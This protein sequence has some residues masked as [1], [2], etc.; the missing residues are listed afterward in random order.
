MDKPKLF[1]A[2]RYV[3]VVRLLDT[4]QTVGATLAAPDFWTGDTH[5]TVWSQLLRP[6]DTHQPYERDFWA[7]LL[8]TGSSRHPPLNPPLPIRSYSLPQSH[9][10]PA[11]ILTKFDATRL[12]R[13]NASVFPSFANTA[14]LASSSSK[15]SSRCSV[16]RM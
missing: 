5:R 3:G 6:L 14:R 7:Q 15:R 9:P 13:S 11:H 10:Y 8:D 16:E 2:Q 1:N 12:N 4:H